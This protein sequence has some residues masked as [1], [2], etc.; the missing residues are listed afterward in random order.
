MRTTVKVLLLL[1]IAAR[2]IIVIWL[3]CFCYME[4]LL[5]VSSGGLRLWRTQYGRNEI[6]NRSSFDCILLPPNQNSLTLC[7]A[8]G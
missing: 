6:L 8:V 7:F 1:A 4:T 3:P 2:E 5:S